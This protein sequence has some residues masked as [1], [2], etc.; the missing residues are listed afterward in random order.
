MWVKWMP[1]IGL[2]VGAALRVGVPYVR[3]GLEDVAKTGNFKSW[4]VFDWRY[5][6]LF[7]L[8]ILEFGMAFLTIDGLW[9]AQFSW[10]FVSAVA[11]AWAGTDIGRDVVGIVSSTYQAVG[12]R[13]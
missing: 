3:A 4:P 10:G 11:M 2:V 5:L 12:K 9:E 8:P 6:A 1:L 13:G 7:L